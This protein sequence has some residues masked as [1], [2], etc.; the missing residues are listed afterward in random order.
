MAIITVNGRPCKGEMGERLSEVLIREGFAV[1]H[2]C[3]GRGSCKKCTVLVD[4][5]EALSCQY[6]ILGDITVLLKEAEAISAPVG[7]AMPE[8]GKKEGVSVSGN[9]ETVLALDIGTTTLALSPV[10]ADGVLLNTVTA[11]NPQRAFGAD[12]MS[13]I[14]YARDRGVEPLSAPLREE[15]GRMIATLGVTSV[16]QL[17]VAANPTMLHLFWG[18]DPTP[19]GTAPYTPA[20]L[21][22]RRGSGAEVGLPMVE[23]VISLPSVSAFVGADLVVGMHYVGRPEG[24]KWRLLIDLGTNAEILL[25]SRDRLYC[26]AAAAGPCFEGAS[27]SC[28]MSAT[29]GAICRYREDGT[30]DTIGGVRACGICGT[31][32]VDAVA[33]L[34]REGLVDEGGYME[35]ERFCLAEGVYLTREDVR[36]YQLA[37]AAVH[38]A[39]LALMDRA[40]VSFD[41]VEVLY[42]AGGFAAEVSVAHA[43]ET[44]LL[45]P[46]LEGRCYAV[47]N[48]S[49]LGC[50][51]VAARP[52]GFTDPT[53]GA[54]YADLSADPVFA[55]LFISH[56]MF[57]EE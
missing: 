24:E 55:D 33:Y 36:R 50:A 4:G 15:I 7:S 37:K 43:V 18:V 30:F 13:R 28:G 26:T 45:P 32:L 27:I 10:D 48:S 54:E 17:Y 19:M 2:P 42:I 9:G 52:E 11:N 49:L 31:G 38:G 46:A 23:E 12:I 5:A 51:R 16:Q 22:L 25:F 1:D 14:G 21:E 44:G 35:E 20:F 40:G 53:P 6:R 57:G 29:P 39:T 3:G 34:L 8:T 56:M 41:D 47:G